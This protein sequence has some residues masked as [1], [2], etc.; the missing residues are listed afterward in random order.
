[1]VK[2]Y[3]LLI[4]LIASVSRVWAYGNPKLSIATNDT[5]SY[6]ESSRVPLFSSEIM[7]GRRLLSTNLIYKVFEPKD[8]YQI[9]VNGSIETH[10]RRLQH[11][12]DRITILQLVLSMIGWG[13]L[14]FVLSEHIKTPLVK[15]ISTA[16]LMAFAFTPQIADWDSILM[17]ESLSFSLFALQLAFLTKL[18]F[19]IYDQSGTKISPYF[20]AWAI[21]FLGWSFLRDTNLF[22]SIITI[23]ITAVFLLSPSRKKDK[24]V[25]AILAFTTFILIFGLY[26]SSQSIRSQIQMTNVYKSDLL[27]SP[28]G[29]ETLKRMGM[30]EPNSKDYQAWFQENSS[31][32]L[33]KFMLLHPGYPTIKLLRDFPAAFTDTK[34]TYFHAPE[35]YQIREALMGIGNALHPENTTPF[36]LDLLLLCGLITLAA[37]NK[38]TYSRPWAWLGFWLFLTATLMMVSTILGDAW[39]LIRHA[40]LPTMMYR[41]FMWMF[42][43]IIMDIAIS[44]TSKQMDPSTQ[45]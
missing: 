33:I 26:T 45:G 15:Y 18:I 44:Q 1:M 35:Q 7:T 30:P 3:I 27:G 17:S 31:K 14:S 23:G 5:L 13:F 19:L 6:V 25:R 36:L 9:S 2:F 34:Q 38:G 37:K 21:T 39:A 12:F 24:N 11:G 42:T 22:A 43:L 40:L 41:L 29:V 20:T 32:T 8:G 28:A 4:I 10:R 16:I